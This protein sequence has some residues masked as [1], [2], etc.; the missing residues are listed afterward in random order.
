MVKVPAQKRERPKPLRQDRS[1][2]PS[3]H[4]RRRALCRARA[5]L[6][7]GR[8]GR[9]GG[10]AAPARR[11]PALPPAPAH[12]FIARLVEPARFQ[13]RP[14]RPRGSTGWCA[15]PCAGCPSKE[16]RVRGFPYPHG[17]N[18]RIRA[19]MGPHREGQTV[20]T[21]LVGGAPRPGPAIPVTQ[22]TGDPAPCVW[23][24]GRPGAIAR[25]DRAL[26]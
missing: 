16:S 4:P 6:P 21:R 13:F 18:G 7:L 20:P 25:A 9:E 14:R 24:Q 10:P 3:H 12:T 11:W 22:P 5:P 19:R 1:N 23:F 15:P 17:G 8:P 26:R 2:P